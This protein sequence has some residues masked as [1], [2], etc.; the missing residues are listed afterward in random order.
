MSVLYPSAATSTTLSLDD[1]IRSAD[2]LQQAGKSEEPSICTVS[3]CNTPVTTRNIWLGSTTVGCCKR[4]TKWTKPS[5]PM[6]N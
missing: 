5:M 6:T 3:G 1:L 4:P 2:M